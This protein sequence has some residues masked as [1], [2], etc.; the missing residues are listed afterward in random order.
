MFNLIYPAYFGCLSVDTGRCGQHDQDE[1][2]ISVELFQ[3]NTLLY[4]W[5]VSNV[6]LTL[7][8]QP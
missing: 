1:D 8:H 7:S 6:S 2:Q 5:M 3:M 4:A